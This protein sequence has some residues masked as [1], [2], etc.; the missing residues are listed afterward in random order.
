MGKKPYVQPWVIDLSIESITGIGEGLMATSC[1]TG[2]EF[3]S[4]SCPS[5]GHGYTGE[6]TNG[7]SPSFGCSNGNAPN[8][9]G[10]LCHN[11]TATEGLCN[12]GTGVTGSH[13]LCSTGS[14]PSFLCN[15]GSSAQYTSTCSPGSSPGVCDF[16]NA[17]LPIS[18]S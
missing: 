13:S 15:L 7:F 5:L 2:P 14:N 3:T 17:Q 8:N 6:C 16:G 11:G 18:S 9:R 1:N 12:D 10:G 4:A